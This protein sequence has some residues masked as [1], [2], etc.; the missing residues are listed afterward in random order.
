MKGTL[1]N[2]EIRH[3]TEDEHFKVEQLT[4]EA[5]WNLYVPGCDEHY[6]VHRMRSHEDYVPELSFIAVKDGDI[7]GSI[8]YTWSFIEN[9]E[10]EKIRTL[11]FGPVCVHPDQQRQGIGSALIG[12]TIRI[13]EKM[14]IPAIIIL[15]DP[16]NY[17]KHGFR[18]GVDC[19]I[20]MYN[21]RQPLG[22]LVLEMNGGIGRNGKYEYKGSDVYDLDPEEVMEFDRRFPFREK[23]HHYSQDLFSMMLR[24]HVEKSM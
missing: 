7:I 11:S 3:E 14:D 12:H 21:G 2:L 22:L 5:F 18:N 4:R 15:G 1:M 19:N 8:M 9:G 23:K 10:G 13:I 6:L 17:C 20:S 16:H 24:S